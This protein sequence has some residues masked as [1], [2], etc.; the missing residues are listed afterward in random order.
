MFFR[1]RF[2]DILLHLTI[3]RDISAKQFKAKYAGSLLGIVWAFLNPLLLALTVAFIFTEII[4][5]RQEH[6]YLFVISGMLPWIFFSTSLQEASV[7]IV[8]NA[9][10]LKQTVMRRE[11]FPLACVLTNL[12]H[13]LIGFLIV[14]P[15]FA[16]VNPRFFAHAPWLI[17]VLL[18][19]FCFTSGL[20]L[21]LAA[22]NTRF[23]DVGQI[24]GVL[25]TFWLWITPVFYGMDMVPEKY[26]FL[27]QVNPMTPFAVLYRRVLLAGAGVD[28]RLLGAAFLLAFFSLAFGRI[29]F[30]RWEPYFLKRL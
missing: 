15:F 6:F 5:V 29:V 7:A 25:L 27:F 13:L 16:A 17:V 20:A 11:L 28:S 23:R 26:R 21:L 22:A 19:H 10:L 12:W 4:R 1:K 14:M 18:L 8:V 9:P 2:R 3:L 24:L 30:S